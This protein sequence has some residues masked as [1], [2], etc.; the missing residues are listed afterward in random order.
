METTT[1]VR[2]F[3]GRATHAASPAQ[4]IGGHYTR[5]LI[6]ISKGAFNHWMP[7]S[8]TV[9]CVRCLKAEKR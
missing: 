1:R 3:G 9:T 4:T 7:S 8:S 5:C 2:L 6:Y